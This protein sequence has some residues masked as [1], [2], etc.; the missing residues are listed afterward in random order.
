MGT[1]GTGFLENARKALSGR[2][3]KINK[4]LDATTKP[5][6]PQKDKKSKNKKNSTYY[7][8]G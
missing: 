3:R 1:L 7:S 6:S 4:A 2:T 5:H 8:D